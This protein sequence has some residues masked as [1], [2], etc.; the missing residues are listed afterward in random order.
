MKIFNSIIG[1][2]DTT[3]VIQP[4]ITCNRPFRTYVPDTNCHLPGGGIVTYQEPRLECPI[5][6]T[7]GYGGFMNQDLFPEYEL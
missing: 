1:E 3:P 5:C 6:D 4:C 2:E 7:H